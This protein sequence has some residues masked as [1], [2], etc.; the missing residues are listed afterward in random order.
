MSIPRKGTPNWR[1]HP[2]EILREEFLKPMHISVYALARRLRVPAPRI[3]DIVLKKRGITADTALRLARFFGTTE[4]F[5]LNLQN[6]YEVNRAKGLLAA[7]IDRIEPRRASELR[8][9]A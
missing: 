5:W 4:H 9:H 3:N 6:A 7:E 2:G 8:T 1:V